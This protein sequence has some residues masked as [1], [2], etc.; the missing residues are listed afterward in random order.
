[1]LLQDFVN[2]FPPNQMRAEADIKE[3]NAINLVG[4]KEDQPAEK[5]IKLNQ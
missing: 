5:K 2:R 1:M 4:S 3:E